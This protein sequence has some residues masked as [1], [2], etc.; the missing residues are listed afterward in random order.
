MSVAANKT[1]PRQA[2]VLTDEALDA[3]AALLLA[4]VEETKDD[5]EPGEGP[6]K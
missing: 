6:P 5:N 2:C 3:L 1:P 4:Y